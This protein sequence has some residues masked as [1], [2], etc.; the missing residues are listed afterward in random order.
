MM[1]KQRENDNDYGDNTVVTFILTSL[2]S[3]VPI[4]Q[5]LWYAGDHN[6]SHKTLVPCEKKIDK[7][8]NN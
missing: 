1:L 7:E 6:L 2:S 8:N 3:L 4:Q 5:S